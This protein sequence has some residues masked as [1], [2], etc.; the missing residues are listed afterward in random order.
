MR[1]L[2]GIR[3]LACM[4]VIISHVVNILRLQVGD[5][6]NFGSSGV[7]IFF[8]L[9][10]FLMSALYSDKNFSVESS[11]KYMIARMARIAP[12]YWIAITFAW[13]LY[14]VLPGFGYEMNAI[15]MLRSL[16]FMGNVGVFWSIPPEIQFYGFFLL[17]WFSYGRLK[18]G[19]YWWAI[20]C[21]ALCTAFI[22][23]KDEWGGLMLPS[24]LHLF[25]GGFLAAFL[26]KSVK[27]RRYLC[28][29]LA[30][31]GLSIAIVV[32]FIFFL[33][34]RKIYEDL[35]IAGLIALFVGSFSQSTLVSRVFETHTMRM[36]GAASFS[37]YLFHDV[38]LQAMDRL[39]VF[40]PLETT[41][42]IMVMCIVSVALPVAFH[43][44]AEKPLNMSSKKWLLEKFETAKAWMTARKT[45]RT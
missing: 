1:P 32:Y 15:A 25:L 4:I 40:K 21:A 3:G 12:A 31:L 23:T 30:Q 9:S 19:N 5:I 36:M 35:I 13:G 24:K 34:H 11:A 6:Y 45:A 20:G 10:G 33:E 26:V 14:M 16:F 18:A 37:I 8:T 39:G 28:S 27:I 7:A 29:N 2:D 42:S 43:Y 44:L 22:I 38:I 17:L 41:I